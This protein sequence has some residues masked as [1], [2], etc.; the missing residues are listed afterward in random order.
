MTY[1]LQALRATEFPWTQRGS[2]LYLN[3]AS[4]GPV[5]VRSLR[6]MSSFN[7]LRGEPFRITDQDE[8][9]T[10][11]RTR[12]LAAALINASPG[13]IA[14]MVNTTYGINVAARCL[15][16]RAGDVVVGYDREF[17][18][19]VYP[20]MARERDGIRT[21]RIPPTPA[22][23]P[24]EAR[25]MDAL[26][27]PDVRVL[28]LS[29]VQ[30][31]SGYRSDLAAL[32]RRCRE[33]GI[34]FVVDAIQGLGAATLD[35][36]ACNIDLLACGGQ[37]WWLS[38]WG[39]GFLYVRDELTRA[40]EPQA[41][42]WMAMHASQD[43]AHLTNYESRYLDD[44]RR[45]EAITL[46]FQDFAGFN[47]SLA[48]LH[49]LGPSHVERHVNDLVDIAVRWAAGR[50]DVRLIT[51]AAPAHRAGIVVLAPADVAAASARLTRARIFHAVRE[52]G[53]RLSPH[54]YDTADEV[55]HALAVMVGED[56]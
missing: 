39:S 43:F 15:P 2:D 25:L 41:V 38:P 11:Q 21:L 26:D 37:K 56:D 28:A 34:W 45:F 40:L 54:G 52:G 29:W 13:E 19:N 35:V 46:P 36:K 55:R 48:M 20:W 42:G 6:A 18:A 49:D 44:A 24:D 33:R 5:P 51:P 22:G 1:D 9:D 4:T 31:A 50:D 23:L 47:A 14:C 8:M 30:F 17:P 3:N 16:L 27:R 32:G 53:I 7:A 12:E 10:V